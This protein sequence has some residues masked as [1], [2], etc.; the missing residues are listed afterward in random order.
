MTPLPTPRH[1]HPILFVLGLTALLGACTN[2]DPSNPWDPSTPAAQQ[3]KGRVR[4]AVALPPGYSPERLAGAGV[5]LF[6]AS[7]AVR[8]IQQAALA[9]PAEDAGAT[10]AGVGAAVVAPFTF[11]GLTAGSYVVRPHIE[12][13]EVPSA[14]F[15]LDIG[16][17]ADVGTLQAGVSGTSAL[18]GLATLDPAPPEGHAG[19]TVEVANSPVT[20]LTNSAGAYRLGVGA[21]T[22]TLQFTAP[23]YEAAS[24][25]DQRVEAG[26]ILAVPAVVLHG[27]P[28]GID[29]LV[30]LDPLFGTPALLG[31]VSIRVRALGEGADAP[32]AEIAAQTPTPLVDDPLR[33]GFAFD[34]LAPGN[35]IVDAALMGFAAVSRPATV[36]LGERANVGDLVLTTDVEGQGATLTGYVRLSCPGECDHGGIRVEA[37]D[38]AFVTFTNSAGE[39]RL[40]V[41]AGQY[42]LSFAHPG[43]V[44]KT[45]GPF[46]VEIDDV[47]PVST[48]DSPFLLDFQPAR[49]V[50]RAL[51]TTADGTLVPAE[52]ASVS[53]TNVSNGE[54]TVAPVNTNAAGEFA[55]QGFAGGDQRLSATLTGH[56]GAE[57]AVTTHNGETTSVGDL[58][59]GLERGDIAGTVALAGSEGRGG[60]TVRVTRRTGVGEAAVVR[61]TNAAAPDDAFA[62]V[63]LPVGTYDLTALAEG[64]RPVTRE[65]L[66]VVAG[67]RVS[68]D[69]ALAARVARI[70]AP[71]G[72]SASPVS[73][74]LVADPDLTFARVWTDAAEAPAGVPFSPLAADGRVSVPLNGEGAHT[75]FAQ[76]ATAAA[77]NPAP[78]T[79][80]LRALSP[81]L[82]AG[83]ALDTRAPTVTA[84]HLPAGAALE[85]FARVGEAVTVSV[86]GFDPA[87]GSGLSELRLA[88]DGGAGVPQ[89]FAPRLTVPGLAAGAHT[90]RLTGVDAAGNAGDAAALSILIDAAAPEGELTADQPLLTRESAVFVRLTARDADDAPLE[91]RVFEAGAPSGAYLPFA[92]AV[93]AA[94][95]EAV[96]VVALRPGDGE[97]AVAAEVRDAAGRVT[98]LPEVVFI[99]DTQ[100]VAPTALTAVDG[101][102]ATIAAG[103]RVRLPAA[104]N[105]YP[106]DLTVA[107]NGADEPLTVRLAGRPETCRID[108][109]QGTACTLSRLP[110]DV[111][112]GG[113]Q[114]VR[115]DAYTEDAAGNRSATLSFGF[116]VDLEAPA[117]GELDLGASVTNALDLDVTLRAAGAVS[118][119]VGGA[120]VQAVPET[121]AAFPVVRRVTLT[122]GDG[123]KPI[124]VTY[125]DEAGNTA[126]ASASIVLDRTAPVFTVS[127]LQNGAPANGETTQRDLGVAISPT[128][129][130][131]GD[132]R[133]LADCDFQARV[134]LR[135]D[136]ADAAFAPFSSQRD[137]LLPP[138]DGLY[139]VHV[140]LRD[141]AGNVAALQA[142][143]RLDVR[144]DQ[145]PPPVPGLRRVYIGADKIRLELT[146]PPVNDLDSLIVQ[147]NLPEQD[148]VWRS[149]DLYPAVADDTLPVESGV[150]ARQT[151]ACVEG[152]RPGCLTGAGTRN[153]ALLLEDRGVVPG[154]AH[155]YRVAAFD[156]I[157]NGSGW[158]GSVEGG[159]PLAPPSFSFF[160]VGAPAGGQSVRSLRW[161]AAPGTFFFDF[162]RYLKFDDLGRIRTITN[163]NL[164]NGYHNLPALAALL[165]PNGPG[166]ISPEAFQT[167]VANVDRSVV[168]QSMARG[169]DVGR[170]ALLE[171][172][173]GEGPVAAVKDAAGA[174]HALT[175]DRRRRLLYVRTE[176][177][178]TT[179]EWSDLLPGVNTSAVLH[180]IQSPAGNLLALTFDEDAGNLR[181]I[182]FTDPDVPV[183]R[184]LGDLCPG[185][186]PD[187]RVVG[188]VA[189]EGATT[190]VAFHNPTTRTLYYDSFGAEP[191]VFAQIEANPMSG[192]DLRLFV[193]AGAVTMIEAEQQVAGTLRLVHLAFNRGWVRTVLRSDILFSDSDAAAMM[194]AKLVGATYHL[195][196]AG[197]RLGGAIGYRFVH[198]ASFGAPAAIAAP[199][200]LYDSQSS[201]SDAVALRSPALL[202]RPN[203]QQLVW[204]A[205][206][207]NGHAA[208][209]VIQEQ[210][211]DGIFLPATVGDVISLDTRGPHLTAVLDADGRARAYVRDTTSALTEFTLTPRLSVTT[212]E[213]RGLSGAVGGTSVSQLDP[214]VSTVP[215]GRGN[216]GITALPAMFGV[217]RSGHALYAFGANDALTAVETTA[218]RWVTS[219]IAVANRA[220]NTYAL[221]VT[222]P[223]AATRRSDL[224]L[225]QANGALPLAATL[226]DT[227]TGFASYV[228][229]GEGARSSLRLATSADGTLHT[230][231]YRV[232]NN[233]AEL[234]YWKRTPADAVTTSV[235]RALAFN[236]LPAV[237]PLGSPRAGAAAG[238]KGEAILTVATAAGVE[239]LF[240]SGNSI[241]AL[242]V[243]NP[244][245]AT[246]RSMNVDAADGTL[247]DAAVGAAGRLYVTYE[248]GGRLYLAP[249]GG[250]PVEASVGFNPR[251]DSARIVTTWRGETGLV[252]SDTLT[253][254]ATLTSSAAVLFARPLQGEPTTTLVPAEI[255]ESPGQRRSLSVY[256]DGSDGFDLFWG[257]AE[258]VAAGQLG[259][260]QRLRVRASADL[261]TT[262]TRLDGQRANGAAGDRDED[263]VA[264]GPDVCPDVFDPAQT[265]TDHDGTGDAC[266]AVCGP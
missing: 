203:G 253:D 27:Q 72:T 92:P 264:D 33:G 67:G 3:A 26:Q 14:D 59:L 34:D 166:T 256:D 97:R 29:G 95:A 43:F 40:Q 238:M 205:A 178:G 181:L 117:P 106:I 99:V 124:T 211:G 239:I 157:G 158:S 71:A 7:D 186:C 134:S 218:N 17:Q 47:L 74:R 121:P 94:D 235:F 196:W 125:R 56:E 73:V 86:T 230:A 241:H 169:P 244:A 83:V 53:L 58:V 119:S 98:T 49:L 243:A 93:G 101:A 248:R 185:A 115:F 11:E 201:G 165:T 120:G 198:Y 151:S 4:G 21:G 110:V 199:V 162:A 62:L 81:L 28:G 183:R 137:L 46:S 262:H 130:N 148:G 154:T 182:D 70:E 210:A 78:E 82:S 197:R 172:A 163:A 222:S 55:L 6:T 116:T 184:D 175:T 113:V 192:R 138:Q 52:G 204:G 202:S 87:P 13:F 193:S 242:N 194:D 84:T 57:R 170:R 102:G 161:H 160:D 254:P 229:E 36:R 180:A 118:Y 143:V 250:T 109:R 60:A 149:V 195:T 51:R 153:G 89:P 200:V 131:P 247:V 48:A 150:C 159:V 24:V 54:L 237:P 61:T 50:G 139:S 76:L 141:R 177:D 15:A 147:R 66:V 207:V 179:R 168:W 216:G 188:Q 226:L 224:Y 91:Y 190:Y 30:R 63:G 5:D 41:V 32:E 104:G 208:V 233:T 9:A 37:V 234:V 246:L 31:M 80:H 88:T 142:N 122:P 171:G 65:G 108:P 45:E 64:F 19:I 85:G 232:T 215:G 236:G 155:V 263:G 25:P 249:F 20:A 133:A 259:L 107:A 217:G 2:V 227:N 75:V 213:L 42:A 164:L 219:G 225:R 146:V 266:E 174:V 221:Y 156:T 240:M 1:L 135:A 79:A 140:Q 144:L 23:G 68:V 265:D 38:K 126:T 105:A 96:A 77:V 173:E 123:P 152:Q 129:E 212:S 223:D 90:L 176:A 145:T 214:V 112:P 252:H 103:A 260:V 251:V 136:F 189:V 44:S 258:S 22:Y 18:E 206:A 127:L 220:G 39:F 261:V 16:G 111:L 8:P 132:C 12:G 128:L 255:L 35:Y 245:A 114:S 191:P 10:D 167:Q 228:A 209:Y 100:A 69:E 231:W 257:A 187:V